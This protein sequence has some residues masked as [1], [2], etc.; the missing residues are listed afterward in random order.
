MLCPTVF[1]KIQ[2][3]MSIFS[4][5]MLLEIRTDLLFIAD[6]GDLSHLVTRDDRR[7]FI[8]EWLESKMPRKYLGAGSETVEIED[9]DEPD[10]QKHVKE[11]SMMDDE[12]YLSNS[13]NRTE[14][15]VG[16]LKTDCHAKVFAYIQ[17]KP[18]LK[19][20]GLYYRTYTGQRS[21][22]I[23]FDEIRLKQELDRG[24]SDVEIK[25]YI[26]D[27]CLKADLGKVSAE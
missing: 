3:L 24:V 11:D 27:L 12:P 14:I 5:E 15:H 7:K 2:D 13:E 19:Q 23:R 26:K 10:E 1:G 25:T 17:Y 18:A 20:K 4:L 22:R 6:A 9:W 16:F 8:I 21:I